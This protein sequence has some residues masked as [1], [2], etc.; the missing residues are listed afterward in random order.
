MFLQF[1]MFSTHLSF[2]LLYVQDFNCSV[3]FVSSPFLVRES[4]FERDNE[5]METLR[6]DEMDETTEM[7]RDADVLVFNTGHWW[8]HEKTSR[9]YVL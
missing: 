8:T 2:V 3:D 6:L 7:Y 4:T 9:G 5:T 1:V